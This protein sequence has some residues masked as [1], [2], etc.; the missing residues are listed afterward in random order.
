MSRRPP[1][2]SSRATFLYVMYY[3]IKVAPVQ[4]VPDAC[5]GRR[6]AEEALHES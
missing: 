3:K 5:W 4:A 6:Q 2:T 1:P